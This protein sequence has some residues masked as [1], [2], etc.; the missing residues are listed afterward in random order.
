MSLAIVQGLDNTVERPGERAPLVLGDTNY[1]QVTEMVSRIARS[2][3]EQSLGLRL[4]GRRRV[5][6]MAGHLHPVPVLH[7]C[8]CLG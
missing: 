3:T 6:F 2:T 1:T 7:G 4:D 5:G 8:G